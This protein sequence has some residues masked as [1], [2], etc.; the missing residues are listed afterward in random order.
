M[1]SEERK[2]V[3]SRSFL[4]LVIVRNES[5][6]LFWS[7][8]GV[9]LRSRICHIPYDREHTYQGTETVIDYLLEVSE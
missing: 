2:D 4:V 5:R 7:F 6:R 3:L 1:S 8:F 9:P